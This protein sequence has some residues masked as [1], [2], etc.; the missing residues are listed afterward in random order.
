MSEVKAD[1]GPQVSMELYNEELNYSVNEYQN[2]NDGDMSEQSQMLNKIKNDNYDD[3]SNPFNNAYD[4]NIGQQ[5]IPVQVN[6]NIND[7]SKI[8]SNNV[9]NNNN[10]NGNINQT[11]VV[12]N[13]NNNNNNIN[14]NVH[15]WNVE[16]YS[17]YFEIDSDILIK[18]L[19]MSLLP[20]IDQSFF[21]KDSN[22]KP[23]L[24]V[25]IYINNILSIYYA[26]YI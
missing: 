13:N 23:E 26:I 1:I 25:Y 17:K 14:K 7:N 21:D 10:N 3:N 9:I 2:D 18:R 8:T 20:F 6:Q 12:S 22:E 11:N 4:D 24:C 16:Y 19:K 15:C 5:M